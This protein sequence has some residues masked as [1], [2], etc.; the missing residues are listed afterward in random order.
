MY[1]G[2]DLHL[3]AKDQTGAFAPDATLT[4]WSGNNKYQTFESDNNG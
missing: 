2:S 3:F 1:E 4:I